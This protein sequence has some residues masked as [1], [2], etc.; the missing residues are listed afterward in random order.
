M[1]PLEHLHL[2]KWSC[3]AVSVHT[4]ID[5]NFESLITGLFLL[6]FF[7]YN[8]MLSLQPSWE[9]CFKILV[10]S[11]NPFLLRQ[12]LKNRCENQDADSCDEADKMAY[13]AVLN[14]LN[15]QLQDK[16]LYESSK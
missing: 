3:I 16:T 11:M 7:Q 5:L 8:A 4:K 1:T 12:L 14:Y 9:D 2:E 13:E 10:P 15:D 6:G